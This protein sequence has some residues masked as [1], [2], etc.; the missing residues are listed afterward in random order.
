MGTRLFSPAIVSLL[1]VLAFTGGAFF[2]T[3]R[4]HIIP[5]R[6]PF[7]LLSM[8]FG[9]WQ[10]QRDRYSQDVIDSLKLHDY[11]LANYQDLSSAER[12]NLYIAYYQT[13]TLG[14]A[15]HSPRTCIPG[16]GWE[17]E[18]LAQKTFEASGV[19]LTVNRAIIGKGQVKQLVYYWFEQR[20]RILASEYDVKWYLLVDGFLKRRSDGALLRVITPIDNR[21]VQVAEARLIRFVGDSYPRLRAFLPR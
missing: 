9:P 20:G 17:L 10:G 1:L 5:E 8:Q 19:R 14:S 13:Q 3:A 21:D 12:I 18:S 7:S 4:P 15:A 11:L 2:I 16:D 6:E